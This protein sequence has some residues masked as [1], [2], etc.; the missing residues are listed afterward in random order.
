MRGG[1]VVAIHGIGGLGHLAIQ[2]AKKFGCRTVALSRNPQKEALARQLGADEFIDTDS[3]DAASVTAMGGAQLILGTAP[4]SEAASALIGGLAPGGQ[5]MLVAFGRGPLEIPQTHL[6]FGARS[7]TGWVG[8]DMRRAVD[9]SLFA[10]VQPMVEEF[11][12]EDAPAAY[13][14][15]MNAEVH[16]RAVLCQQRNPDAD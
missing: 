13:E 2:Y 15:M 7:V 14:K 3:A 5:L 6:L 1:D 16:F 10:Q 11:S 4:N 8:G 9:F 12:L